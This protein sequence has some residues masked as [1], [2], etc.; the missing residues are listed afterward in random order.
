MGLQQQLGFTPRLPNPVQ[1]G[2]QSVAQTKGGSWFFQR[3][4]YR[5]DR[6][7]HRWTDGRLMLSTVTA[8]I[9][10]IMLTTTGAKSGQPRT[11][12]VMGVPL[13][14]DIALLGTNY[15]QPKAPAWS[16]NLVAHPEATVSYRDRSVAVTA[17]AATE[18]E[19]EQVWATATRFYSG[20]AKYRVR[21]T[22]R[23]VRM[24]VLETRD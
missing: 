10:V 3:T 16:F 21:I 20:F 11:M 22:D 9:P 13:G 12:P 24:F 4:L 18:A 2:M 7:I 17:R 1:R 5:V 15:A 6:P 19:R 23:P 14:D 8:G